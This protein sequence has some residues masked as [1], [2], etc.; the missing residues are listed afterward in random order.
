MRRLLWPRVWL[1][2]L[3][4]GALVLAVITVVPALLRWHRSDKTLLPPL[5][6]GLLVFK[7]VLD[8]HCSFW[9]TLISTENRLPM[10]WPMLAG[11]LAGLLGSVVMARETSLGVGSFVLATLVVGTLY[12]YWKWPEEGARTFGVTLREFLLRKPR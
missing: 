5:W 9:N 12:N 8:A 7:G 10:V 11:N 6:L 4:Y 3:T 2:Y 1:Q